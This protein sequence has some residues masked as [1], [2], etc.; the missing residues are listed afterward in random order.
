MS[1]IEFKVVKY[2]NERLFEEEVEA[3]LN[4]GFHIEK[5]ALDRSGSWTYFYAFMMK[6]I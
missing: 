5:I 6:G 1:K 4:D 3:L 2:A